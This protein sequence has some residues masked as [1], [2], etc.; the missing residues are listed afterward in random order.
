MRHENVVRWTCA[1]SLFA[2]LGFFAGRLAAEGGKT[3]IVWPAGDIKWSE[4]PAIAGAKMSVLWGDPKT[5][6]YGALKR[7]KGGTT[8]AEHTHSSDQH[9]IVIA[10]TIAFSLS[11]GAV[12]DIGPGSYVF[13][14]AGV[15]HT[16]ACKAG[17][18]CTYFEEQSGPADIKYVGAPHK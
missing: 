3:P 6:G 8:L 12:K 11:G 4:S 16:A 2:L 18:D 17:T 5:A 9:V 10:G 7:I 14:P 15:K 1:L 13:M